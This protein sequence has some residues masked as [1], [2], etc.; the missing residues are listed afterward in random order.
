M[1]LL[2]EE[3][4]ERAHFPPTAPSRAASKVTSP[5]L[6]MLGVATGTL[7]LILWRL[8]AEA[9]VS[10]MMPRQWRS[11]LGKLSVTG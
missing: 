8:L 10:A 3:Y 6:P 2:E 7:P 4:E 11:Q 5:G 9:V 1:C